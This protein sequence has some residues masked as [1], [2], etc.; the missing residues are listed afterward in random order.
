MEKITAEEARWLRQLIG[1]TKKTAPEAI[2]R[3]LLALKLVKLNVGGMEITDEGRLALRRAS[4]VA[5]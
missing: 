3:R 2:Q 1:A 4:A 5:P